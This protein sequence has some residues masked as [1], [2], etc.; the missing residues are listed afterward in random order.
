LKVEPFS[1]S[2]DFDK[3]QKEWKDLSYWGRRQKKK[4][5]KGTNERTVRM[6]KKRRKK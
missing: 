5:S 2:Y 6:R 4:K 3:T 1:Y